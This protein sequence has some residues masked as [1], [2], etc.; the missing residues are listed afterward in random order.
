MENSPYRAISYKHNIKQSISL[1][2]KL[3]KFKIPHF[4]LDKQNVPMYE[5]QQQRNSV[6]LADYHDS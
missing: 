3:Q 6:K 2:C 5:T 1:M 4:F